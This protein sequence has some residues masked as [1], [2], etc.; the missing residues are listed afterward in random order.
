MMC[1]HAYFHSSGGLIPGDV[2]THVNGKAVHDGSEV[3][4]AVGQFQLPGLVTDGHYADFRKVASVRVDH[5]E[6]FGDTHSHSVPR[7][8]TG[9]VITITSKIHFV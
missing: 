3:S 7:T 9:T 4:E 2:I 1:G 5:F 8:A 6:E